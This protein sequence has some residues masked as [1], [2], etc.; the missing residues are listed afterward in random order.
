VI[1]WHCLI[2][3]T[4]IVSRAGDPGCKQHSLAQFLC[5][6]HRV[7]KMN[8]QIGHVCARP[9]W[10]S[11]SPMQLRNESLCQGFPTGVPRNFVITL[12]F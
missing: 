7:I 8:A 10:P 4:F 11:S 2:K 6:S 3:T 9:H 12:Y 5:S 1:A